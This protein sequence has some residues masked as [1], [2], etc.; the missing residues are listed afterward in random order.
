MRGK[1]GLLRMMEQIIA[2]K[3][4]AARRESFLPLLSFAATY[5]SSNKPANGEVSRRL[6]ALS[7]LGVNVG[8]ADLKK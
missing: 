5:M 6:V 2:S 7:S 3:S 1:G 4:W 8:D